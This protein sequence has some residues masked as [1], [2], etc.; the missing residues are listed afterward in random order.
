MKYFKDYKEAYRA[1]NFMLDAMSFAR[2]FE[3]SA[4][5]LEKE[6]KEKF[7]ELSGIVRTELILL[8]G[9]K[10]ALYYHHARNNLH[11]CS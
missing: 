4:P 1:N 11:R 6:L 8:H 2:T 9:F 3:G 10:Q 5:E 7:P